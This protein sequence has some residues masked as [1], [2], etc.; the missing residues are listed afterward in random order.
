[1]LVWRDVAW[2]D[3]CGCSHVCFRPTLRGTL[4]GETCLPTIQRVFS[5]QDW[6]WFHART[7]NSL[8][9]WVLCCSSSQVHS[10]DH[11]HF[12][13][14]RPSGMYTHEPLYLTLPSSISVMMSASLCPSDQPVKNLGYLSS[15]IL[16]R[17]RTRSRKPTPLL[18][19]LSPVC[20]SH[21]MI[22][23][24]PPPL[25]SISLLTRK[26]WIHS[27]R[28]TAHCATAWS[29]MI[30]VPRRLASSTRICSRSLSARPRCSARPFAWLCSTAVTPVGIPS[31]PAA[32]C[33][34]SRK[35]SSWSQYT[36]M[37]P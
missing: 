15:L 28:R 2:I 26:F 34:T 7:L 4:C 29:S 17:T 24:V 12:Q 23:I 19:A 11:D 1:M 8:A 3:Q 6:H 20:A 35:H 18:G 25:K 37:V 14:L 31:R 16:F 21:G 10:G 22:F 9:L 30:S 32:L 33:T 5:D 36:G 27:A 13:Q